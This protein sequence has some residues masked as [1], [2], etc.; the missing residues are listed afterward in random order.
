[1]QKRLRE[2]EGREGCQSECG[3]VGVG[4]W[5]EEKKER[6]DKKK[7]GGREKINKGSDAN[8]ADKI[9]RRA[10]YEKGKEPQGRRR[11]AP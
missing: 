9:G 10:T 1:M 2:K 8:R 4:V 7:K 5:C 3:W 6:T 11:K